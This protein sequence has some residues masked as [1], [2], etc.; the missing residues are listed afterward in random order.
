MILLKMSITNELK[1][2]FP[3]YCHKYELLKLCFRSFHNTVPSY[4]INYLGSTDTALLQT[5]SRMYSSDPFS[6]QSLHGKK[7]VKFMAS[8]AWSDFLLN[9]PEFDVNMSYLCF[10][11]FPRDRLLDQQNSDFLLA[12][13]EHSNCDF[14]CIESAIHL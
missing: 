4:F 5:R 14:S 11:T 1:W 13:A 8:K 2:L 3:N 7:S 10:K 12:D 9:N 6:T